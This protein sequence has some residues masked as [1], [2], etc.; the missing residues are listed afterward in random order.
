MRRLS[1]TLIGAA[2]V[3]VS[4]LL[5]LIHVRDLPFGET[6]APE[7]GFVPKILGWFL[8]FLC[9]LLILREGF[10][11]ASAATSGLPPGEP[12]PPKAGY[13]RALAAAAVLVAYPVTM[14]HAGFILA[15]GLGLLAIFRVI[16]YRSW[17]GSLL[18][19]AAITAVSYFVFTSLLGV[20]FPRGIFG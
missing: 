6:G 15:T 17:G 18:A 4:S 11:P 13:R 14:T 9:F 8:L 19:A 5:Y 12:S 20:Y 10:R 2:A 7:T 16:Q 3:A 1:P